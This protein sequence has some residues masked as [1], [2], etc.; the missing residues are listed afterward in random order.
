MF[1]QFRKLDGEVIATLFVKDLRYFRNSD[2]QW[3]GNFEF[4]RT[5]MK[6]S[7]DE[8]QMSSGAV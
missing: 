5:M 2:A 3:N 1:F 7:K 4:C 6:Q 8:S